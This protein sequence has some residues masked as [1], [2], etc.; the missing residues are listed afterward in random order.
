MIV[1]ELMKELIKRSDMDARV[2]VSIDDVDHGDLEVNYVNCAPE[3]LVYLEASDDD[4]QYEVAGTKVKKNELVALLREYQYFRDYVV[5][6]GEISEDM[7][8]ARLHNNSEAYSTFPNNTLNHLL[9]EAS[10]DI[11]SM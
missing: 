5:A 4:S 6:K 11:L 3:K 8:A 2:Y 1:R 9:Q 7:A 10:Q